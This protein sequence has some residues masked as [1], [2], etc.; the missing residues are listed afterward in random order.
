MAKLIIKLINAIA[1]VVNEDPDMQGR[2]K[3]VFVP[4]FNVTVGERVYPAAD[5]SEQISMAGKEASGTGNMKFALNGALTTGTLDG[6]NIEIRERVGKENFFLFGLTADEVVALKEGGYVPMDYYHGNAELEAAIDAIATGTF[7]EGN[8]DLF[9]PIVESLLQHDEYLVLA[10]Y[11]SYV[12]CQNLA[13]EAYLD[14][15]S[16]ARSSI[17][18]TAHCGFFSSDRAMAQYCSGIWQVEPIEV[19]A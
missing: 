10:D 6:A 17:L 7:S 8:R 18:N 12:K 11:D 19:P 3:V 5:I 15:A 4:N 2:L 16:W 1:N 13:A 14:P 9:Q